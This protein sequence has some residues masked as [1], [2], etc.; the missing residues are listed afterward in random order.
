MRAKAGQEETKKGLGMCLYDKLGTDPHLGSAG[1]DLQW[2][3]LANRT[4]KKAI[5]NSMVLITVSG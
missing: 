3:K 1:R 2:V 5:S 4:R